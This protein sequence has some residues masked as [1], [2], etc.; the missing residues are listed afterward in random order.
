MKVYNLPD[1]LFTLLCTVLV[2][3]FFCNTG[4]AEQLAGFTLHGHITGIGLSV[5]TIIGPGPEKGTERLYASHTYLKNTLDIVAMDVLTG[6]SDVF[7][8]PLASESGAWAIVLGPDDHVYIGTLPTAH[9][10]R[11]DWKTKKLVDMGRPSRTEEYI[12]QLVLG[13]DKKIYGCTYPN[14]KLIRFNPDTGISEDLG[15]MSMTENYAR[16]LSADDR[17]FIY[18][19]IGMA[20]RD[21]VTYEIATGQ[22][23]S[24]LPQDMKGQGAV[25]VVRGTD[26]LVY[27]GVGNKWLRMNGFN[28][29]PVLGNFSPIT[30]PL[31]LTDGRRV[32]YEGQSVYVK[33][34]DE[35]AV[36]ST[37]LYRGKPISIFRIGLGPD[38][39]L[40]GSTA[41][42]GHFFWASPDSDE[43]AEI[44]TPGSGEIYSFLSWRD[45][46]ISA[47]YSFPSPIM[48]YKPDQSWKPGPKSENN[49]LQIHYKGE[50]PS[51]RP[52]AMIAGPQEKVYIG[53]VSGYGLL[54]GPLCVFDPV[55]GRL[56][57]YTHVVQD[58]SV[59]SL[60]VTKEGM[61]VGGT[62]IAG[63]GGSHPTQAEA[64]IFLWDPVKHEKLFETVPAIGNSSI[65][66][67]CVGKDGLV[68]GF[69]NKRIMF[70]FDPRTR[71]IVSAK[72]SGIGNV[73]YNA[74]G[75]G[76]DGKL[77]GL[78]TGGIFTIDEKEHEIKQI[79]AYPQ[80]IDGGFAIRGKRIYFTSGPRIVSYMLP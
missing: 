44:A 9:I 71:K 72:P 54:G 11:L 40:Y 38:G 15:R 6:K 52:V 66:A 48:I 45:K 49:P 73:I 77:Y 35:K 17:G 80:G 57:Q 59:I 1:Y 58:H 62:T 41:V 75:R 76:A 12:W 27:A 78:H 68:Y 60:A 14:A 74:I 65:E 28:A 61:I 55:T 32:T 16:F 23:K 8:S 36:Q 2:L 33:N 31:T 3:L 18:V 34:K 69:A 5:A 13:S 47:A 51:W 37:T 53:A 7:S 22:H 29:T 25:N 19:G 63:G 67:L 24:I 70:V 30:P 64:K 43:W 79:V 26:G 4:R 39:R 20:N 46:L 42:P 50:N 10:M 21:L 56:D